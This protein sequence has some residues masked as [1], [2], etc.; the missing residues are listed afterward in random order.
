MKYVLDHE[1]QYLDDIKKELKTHNLKHV[2]YMDYSKYFYVVKEGEVLGALNTSYFWDWCSLGDMYY[3][4]LN[5][6]RAMISKVY[7]TYKD[8]VVGLKLYTEVIARANEFK[9]IGFQLVSTINCTPQASTYYFLTCEAV[10]LDES[11]DVIVSDEKIPA[12]DQ[13]LVEK[14]KAYEATNHI[15]TFDEERIIFVALNEDQFVG[16]LEAIVEADYMYVSRLAVIESEKHK[17]I[18]SALMKSAEEK[19]KS[20][21][22]FA[23]ILGTADFQAKAFYEKL[24][25]QIYLT[26]ENDPKGYDSYSMMKRLK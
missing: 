11:F 24:G 10:S 15:K 20:L 25:Y 8:D 6:L 13:V 7:E 1:E 16:G 14:V 3:E 19:A 21:D 26:K 17:G 9:H 23:V 12:Y 2:S 22:L 4:H 5:V 18:G